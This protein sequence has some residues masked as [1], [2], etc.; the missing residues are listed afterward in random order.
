MN[1]VIYVHY[2]KKIGSK[3][4]PIYKTVLLVLIDYFIN[5]TLRN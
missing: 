1:I 3:K 2:I 5:F 4:P